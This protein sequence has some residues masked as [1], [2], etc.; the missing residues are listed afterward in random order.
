MGRLRWGRRLFSIEGVGRKGTGGEGREEGG[1]VKC[2]A[3][4]GRGR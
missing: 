3:I 4:F 1:L 2:A